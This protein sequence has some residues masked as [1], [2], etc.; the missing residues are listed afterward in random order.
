MLN[1]RMGNVNPESNILIPPTIPSEIH[2]YILDQ[3]DL[4]RN[5]KHQIV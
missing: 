2:L 1:Y 4:L 3:H 5:A